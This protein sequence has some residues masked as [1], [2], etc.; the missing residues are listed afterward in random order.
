VTTNAASNVEETTSTING[1][2]TDTGGENCDYRGFV[3][4]T[5]SH[6]D[7]GNTAPASS[8][9]ASNWT[10]SGSYGTGT[11]NHAISALEQGTRYYF[12]ACTHNSEGWSYGD[13]Q[14]FFSKPDPPTGFSAITFNTTRIDLSWTKGA[15]ASKTKIQRKEGSYPVDRNDGTQVY[16]DTGTAISDTGLTPDETY[17]YRAWSY[18]EGS[19]QWSDTYVQASANTFTDYDI[20]LA[21]GWT[22][23]SLPFIPDSTD[24]DAVISNGTLSSSNVTNIVMVYNYNT[25][26]EKWLWWNGTPASTLNTMVDGKAYWIYAAIADTL[27]VHGTQAGHPGPDYQ[28]LTG[29]NMVGFTSTSDMAIE[30]YLASEDGNYSLLYCWVDGDWLLWTTAGSTFTNMEP[31]CGYW[32][33]I[34]A[35]G[36][37]TPP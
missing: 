15:G 34:N 26:A 10:E 6:G 17:Y 28:V 3:W 35:T 2:I 24:I 4:G 22:L 9:Y 1:D 33:S 37:I 23:V 12:R 8:D 13:E 18:V 25:T 7:P 14:S 21:A 36:T 11:F 30:S 32:L 20:D 27:T 29:W 5:T 31:G 19:E 16:F